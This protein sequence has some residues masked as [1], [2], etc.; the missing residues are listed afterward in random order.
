M[1][2][3]FAPIDSSRLCLAAAIKVIALDRTTWKMVH[4]RVYAFAPCRASP[5]RCIVDEEAS[6]QIFRR[7]IGSFAC[8]D[9][10]SC[11]HNIR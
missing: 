2:Y 9:L 3:S 5:C 1:K 11:L 8:I 4:N 7:R 6:V 10:S